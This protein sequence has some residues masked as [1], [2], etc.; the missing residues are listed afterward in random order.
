MGKSFR[1]TDIIGNAGC[2]SEKYDKRIANKCLRAKVKRLLRQDPF[3][4]VLPIIREISDVWCF[5]KDGK[6]WFGDL[7]NSNMKF[8]PHLPYTEDLFFNKMYKKHKRK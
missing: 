8:Y 1:K 4:E 6:N 7:K 2:S 5:G 3:V